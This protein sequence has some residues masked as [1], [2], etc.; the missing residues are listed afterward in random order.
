MKNEDKLVRSDAEIKQLQV[1][2]MI[3]ATYMIIALSSNIEL[4]LKDLCDLADMDYQI[5][6]TSYFGRVDN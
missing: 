5:L 6:G 4:Q 3:K 2:T 1:T